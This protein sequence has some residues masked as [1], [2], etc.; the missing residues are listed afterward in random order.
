MRYKF[1]V[2]LAL[3]FPDVL[4]DGNSLNGFSAAQ[5]LKKKNPYTLEEL[6]HHKRGYAARE[7][8][9]LD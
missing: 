8:I 7:L 1:E 9:I 5:K 6:R 3:F 2:F 4:N